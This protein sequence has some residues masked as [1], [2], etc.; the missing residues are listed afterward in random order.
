MRKIIT[1]LISIITIMLFLIACGNNDAVITNNLNIDTSVVTGIS[2]SNNEEI[3]EEESETTEEEAE[4]E[5]TEELPEED[6]ITYDEDPLY[7]DENPA[8]GTSRSYLTNQWVTNEVQAIRPITVMFPTDQ[9]A[10][11]QYN[12]GEAGILY[13]IMAEGG[14]SRMM[15]VIQGWHTMEKIG[16]IR[17]MRDYFVYVAKE[18]NPIMIHHGNIWYADEVLST[19]DHIDGTT[20]DSSTAFYRTADKEAPHNSFV[21]GSGILE[22]T[23]ETGFSLVHTDAEYFDHF[24]FTGVAHQNAFAD[25]TD[26]Y[27]ATY[28]DMSNAFAINTPYFEY[29][30]DTELYDR[31]MYGKEH[32]DAA[33][34]KQLSFKN[35]I[36]QYA[37]WEEKPDGTYLTFLMHDNTRDGWYLTNGKAIHITWEKTSDTEP[38]KYYDD[39]GAEIVLNTGKT[40]IFIVQEDKEIHFE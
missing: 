5:T 30:D 33:T 23:N 34:G 21:S 16:N 15:G 8:E 20:A 6:V 37:Y 2:N 1:L 12:I 26:V 10:Q 24:I 14:I 9:V 31:F 27:D 29:N 4:S 3:T 36:I 18:W 38:T 13:E 11:P 25:Y 22:Y 28:L 19:V 39:N 32:V 7:A 17:S 40:M 35:I